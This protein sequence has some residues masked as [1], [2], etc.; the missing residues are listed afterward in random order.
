MNSPQELKI[1]VGWQMPGNRLNP[2]FGELNLTRREEGLDVTVTIL[3]EPVREGSQTGVALDG[4]FSMQSPFGQAHRYS[5]EFT[6]ETQEF[7]LSKGTAKFVDRDGQKLLEFTREGWNELLAQKLLIPTEN[8]VEPIARDVIP[9]LAEK[10]DADG[11]TTVIHWACGSLGKKVEIVGDLTAD[12][13]RKASYKGP[14]EWGKGTYLLPALRYFVER[15]PDAKW[16]FYV[17]V[18]DGRI[19]DLQE[20]KDY[21]ADLARRISCGQANP[22]KCVLIGVGPEVD[23]RQMKELDDLPDAMDLDVDI[24]DHKVA[25]TMRGLR[26]IFAE[27]VDENVMVAPTGRILCEGHMVANFSDGLP[28]LL[29][30]SMPLSAKSFVLDV[31]GQEIEQTLF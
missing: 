7:H 2:A 25:A 31:G 28:A 29:K 18:T 13:A 6:I 30:F 17:F 1:G 5:P 14:N 11:G 3:M 9:Y 12:E 27:V 22:V 19:D 15:F 16:G 4:S 23:E 10:I 26:D 21:T 20:V 8:V 24:W